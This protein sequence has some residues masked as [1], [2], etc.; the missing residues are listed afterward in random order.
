MILLFALMQIAEP[1]ELDLRAFEDEEI[2]GE[3]FEKHLSCLGTAAHDRRNDTRETREVAGDVVRAC[4][5]QAAELRQQLV[6]VYG[7]KPDL[8]AT[9]H[10]AA[11]ASDK[12]IAAV[13]ERAEFVVAEDRKRK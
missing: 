2:A 4:D 9:N 5:A 1:P 6:K 3:A 13:H 11:E 12:F 10:T 8:V 7:R